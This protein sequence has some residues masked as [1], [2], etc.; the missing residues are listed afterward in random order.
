MVQGRKLRKD[1]IGSILLGPGKLI[2]PVVGYAVLYPIILA[3]SGQ[4]VLGLWSLLSGLLAMLTLVDLGFSAYLKRSASACTAEDEWRGVVC[5]TGSA[6]A[7]F[8]ALSVAGGLVITAAIIMAFPAAIDRLEDTYS[9]AALGA[10]IVLTLVTAFAQLLSRLAAAALAS[11]QQNY[12][13]EVISI[14]SPL[15][16]FPIAIGGA[17]IGRPVES[18][19]LGYCLGA[20]V[21]FWTL[22]DRLSVSKNISVTAFLMAP[23]TTLRSTKELWNV[24]RGLFLVSAGFAIREPIVRFVAASVLGLAAAAWLDI[25]MRLTIMT[26]NVIASGTSVL[27][28]MISAM[29]ADQ[30]DARIVTVS[31]FSLGFLLCFVTTAELAILAGQEWFYSIWLG[32]FDELLRRA[33]IAFAIW[34]ITV[35]VNVPFWHRIVA[36]GN[37]RLAAWS[38]WLQTGIVLTLVP[39]SAIVS[40]S[41]D[42]LLFVWLLGAVLTQVMIYTVA[43]VKF[44]G[45]S[46]V[47]GSRYILASLAS[48]LVVSSIVVYRSY[49][50]AVGLGLDMTS[51][52]AVGAHFL[53]SSVCMHALWRETQPSLSSSSEPIHD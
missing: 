39:L 37:E 25:A 44:A 1:L 34:N 20:I 8:Y 11:V 22:S 9:A 46:S 52:I 40:L 33:T 3:K 42:T 26:K 49:G 47:L 2:V 27:F 38:L 24:S 10:A 30:S 17:I 41:F 50:P 4:A 13:V 6:A 28:P 29:S 14:V 35:I 19:A 15:I 36:T 23:D 32:Q 18:L 12:V 31:K 7:R 48:T 45:V 21:S 51:L 53:V 5:R 16:A 43:Q